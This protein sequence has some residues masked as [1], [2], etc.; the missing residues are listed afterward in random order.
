MQKECHLKHATFMT[1]N[2]VS[3]NVTFTNRHRAYLLGTIWNSLL[4]DPFSADEN[5]LSKCMK[6]AKK[7]D[8]Q[9]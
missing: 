2:H 7:F 4:N 1:L 3:R 5:V 6:F 8:I 9:I